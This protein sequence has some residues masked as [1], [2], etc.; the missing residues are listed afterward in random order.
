MDFVH[1][2]R[3]KTSNYRFKK[4]LQD[5]DSLRKIALLCILEIKKELKEQIDKKFIT[6]F[7]KK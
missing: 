7:Y 4:N 3:T 6:Y 5:D 1:R 2:Y